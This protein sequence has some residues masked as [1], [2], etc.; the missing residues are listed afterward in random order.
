M[1]YR[2]ALGGVACTTKTTLLKKLDKKSNNISVHLSDYKEFNDEYKMD[3]RVG[4]LFWIAHRLMT[5][6]RDVDN[7]TLNVYDR[8]PM[9]SLVYEAIRRDINLEDSCK[10]FEQS[11]K[12]NFF[13]DW[14]LVFLRVKPGTESHVVKMMR[15]RNNGIDLITEDYVKKQ[16]ERFEQMTRYYN[17]YEY[18]ID[19]SKDLAQQQAEIEQC[20]MKIIYNWYVVDDSMYVFEC[21]LPKFPKV[22]NK[23]K[24]AGFDLDN[25]LI[26]T[27]SGNVFPRDRF[28]WQ[29]KY[30][31]IYETFL[32]LIN[33][34]Y[35]IVIVT[36][37]LGISFNKITVQDV[38][39]KIRSIC[40][41]LGLPMI[42]MIASK[43][44]KYRKPMTGSIDYLLAKYGIELDRKN[45]FFCGDDVN[46]TLPS[47]SY[48]ANNCNINFYNDEDYFVNN[49]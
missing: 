6:D 13:D 12:M 10:I 33:N 5:D 9:E 42:V 47:D 19:F 1:S 39:H 16:N 22:N 11:A 31:N 48:F 45:S 23:I 34:K 25:T 29:W 27:K 20:L 18:V 46:G 41:I 24:I 36:N 28:D 2:L 4:S 43:N 7:K 37:Q 44:D 17:A 26:V 35:T 38:E 32:N 30:G 40:E 49:E 14:K 3:H 21:R 15:K 8:H